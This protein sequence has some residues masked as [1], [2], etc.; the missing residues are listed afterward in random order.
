MLGTESEK[1][2]SYNHKL[3]LQNVLTKIEYSDRVFDLNLREGN[4]EEQIDT[5]KDAG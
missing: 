1:R 3:V 4:N 2:I 5:L